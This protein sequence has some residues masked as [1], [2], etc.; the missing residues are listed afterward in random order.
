MGAKSIGQC[1]LCLRCDVELQ[2]S[3]FLPKGIYR[4]LRDDGH[5]NPNPFLVTGSARVQTSWQMKA[6]LL[7]EACEGRFCK[8]GE[9]WVLR[10]CLKKD[11]SF[12]LAAWLAARAPDISAAGA[13]TRIYFAANIPEIDIAAL[14]YFSASIF[15]R[16]SI[17]GWNSDGSIP[18]ELG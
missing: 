2:E 17:H 5:P 1:R 13:A 7:C 11:G 12:R 10:S 3:H 16:A 6:N 18:V 9:D 15:W 14:S 4:I 8:N